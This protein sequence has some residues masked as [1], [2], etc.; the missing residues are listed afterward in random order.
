MGNEN[1]K[2]TGFRIPS[3][4]GLRALSISLVLLS[5]AIPSLPGN[6]EVPTVLEPIIHNGHLG[7]SIFFVISGYLITQLLVRE[8]KATGSIG[9][10]DFYGRRA[11]RIFPPFYAYLMV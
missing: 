11:L 5:H 7:V 2:T 9:L 3:L 10:R 6:V 1:E 4:D 8:W